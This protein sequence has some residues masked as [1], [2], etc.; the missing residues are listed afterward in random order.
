MENLLFALRE[1]TCQS[2]NTHRQGGSMS[3]HRLVLV[4]LCL[5]GA[6][7]CYF[8]YKYS[9]PVQQQQFVPPIAQPVPPLEVKPPITPPAQ[10]PKPKQQPQGGCPWCP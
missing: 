5:L 4:I 2:I 7:G 3:E 9:N 8:A 10:P 6:G 1:N